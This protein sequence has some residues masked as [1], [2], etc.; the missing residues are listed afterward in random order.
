MLVAGAALGRYAANDGFYL[1]AAVGGLMVV[2]GGGILIWAGNH[3]SDLHGPLRAGESPV[4]PLGA[5]LVGF[6]ATGG[7][8]VALLV[9]I[10]LILI[11]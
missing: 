1:Y 6:G 2:L 10:Q 9:A 8:F 11:D 4:H 5:R 3:Y 7:S